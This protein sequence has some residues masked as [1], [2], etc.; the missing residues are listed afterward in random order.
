[1]AEDSDQEKTE[2]ATPRKKEKAREK[3]QV[4][5]SKE[6]ATA[7]VLIS[8]AIGFLWIGK[9]LAMAVQ[10][11]FIEMFT[12]E[13]AK[14]YD[15]HAFLN[16]LAGVMSGLL[17]PMSAFMALV[18]ICA[19]IGS[20]ALGGVTI[21]AEAAS[22]KWNKLSPLAGFKRMFGPQAGVELIKA[23]AKFLVVASVAILMLT[24]LFPNILQVSEKASPHDITS[25]MTLF[26]WMFV[27]LCCSM[28]LIVLID[29]PF[30]IYNHN[31]QLKMSMQEIKDEYK[32][33]EGNPE[34]KRRIRKVQ[35]EMAQQRMMGEVPKA[36]VVVTNPDHFAVAL[37]YDT[38]GGK[39]PVVIAK[40]VDFLAEQIRQLAREHD[41]PIMRQPTLARAIFYTTELDREIPGSL[42]AAVAQILAYV[43]Q[44]KMFQQ[45]KGA[46]PKPLSVEQHIPTELVLDQ[47]GKPMHPTNESTP[48]DA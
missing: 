38:N 19:F 30:Q 16:G 46:R 34:I 4:P 36:D 21:S 24:W 44:L 27:G 20:I 26:L 2:E 6:L 32:D 10:Q 45:G 23:I 9:S 22:P 13:R 41:V 5:R 42:F 14:I 31:K 33:T 48:P 40:G 43:F 18:F 39:A 37:R 29:V 35:M 17:G 25:A 15:I 3:G 8:S 28:L 47:D 11:V 12:I 7:A 1:M